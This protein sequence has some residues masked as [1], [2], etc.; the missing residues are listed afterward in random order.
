MA[1]QNIDMHNLYDLD[2]E[3]AILASILSNN[4][5]LGEI[6]DI[7]KASDFYLKGHADIYD[8]MVQCLNSDLPIATSFLKNKLGGKYDEN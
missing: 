6:F 8:A 1:Q 7:I 2:M 5:A 4:D 3:R